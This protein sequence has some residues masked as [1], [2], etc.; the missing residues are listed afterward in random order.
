MRGV[1]IN[2]FAIFLLCLTIYSQEV[3]ESRFSKNTVNIE[4]SAEQVMSVKSNAFNAELLASNI[5]WDM[6]KLSRI[7]ESITG[8]VAGIGVFKVLK[9][10]YKGDLILLCNNTEDDKNLTLSY[11]VNLEGVRRVWAASG[12]ADH[13]TPGSEVTKAIADVINRMINSV[14]MWYRG[15]LLIWVLDIQ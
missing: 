10:K 9:D 3:Y 1:F 4:L 15:E 8:K 7:P 5:A 2:T 14:L 12:V 11:K 6:I 13:A